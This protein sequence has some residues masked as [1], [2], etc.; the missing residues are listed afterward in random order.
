MYRPYFGLNQLPFKTTPELAMF[1]RDGSREEILQ[2]LEYT[3]V[4]GDGILK[5]VGE[6]GC[7]KTMI[8]RLL[9]NEL[10][11][12]FK[13]IYV[14]SPNLSAK[15]MLLF[16]CSELGV[17]VNASEQKFSLIS[18]LQKRLL[19]LYSQGKKVVML[20]DEAQSMTLDGLEEIRLLSNLETD[21]D[22]LLQVVLF[23]Q[24]ELDRALEHPNIR[25]LKSRIT[26]SIYIPPFSIQDVH[27]YLNFR[28]RKSGY[29][30]VDVF[31][32]SAAKKITKL[33]G[34]YP[35]DINVVADKL[36]MSVFSKQDKFV[37]SKH[38]SAIEPNRQNVQWLRQASVLL[39]ILLFAGSY[40]L[41]ANNTTGVVDV[42]SFKNK[43]TS[44]D[45][46]VTKDDIDKDTDGVKTY[47]NS[48]DAEEVLS[49]DNT[50]FVEEQSS[51]ADVESESLTT[52][53]V[54]QELEY[55]SVQAKLA[56]SIKP[57]LIDSQ[58]IVD[59]LS[60]NSYSIQLATITLDSYPRMQREFKRTGVDTR[61]IF[62]IL[63]LKEVE[64][65]EKSG[66]LRL[67]V[68][69]GKA[70][71]YSLAKQMLQGLPVSLQRSKPF[72]VSSRIIKKEFS[73]AL[74]F[75]TNTN[76]GSYVNES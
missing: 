75:V 4:R 63:D 27:S 8:L 58:G 47:T 61:E 19:Q 71:S 42:V 14:N 1:Y 67:K 7:G 3:V 74:Q 45:S 52:S 30:G 20:I 54:N 44:Y 10:D 64:D 23:G 36:L 28:M 66:F 53:R 57:F 13:L 37:R 9:A 41:Y 48:H 29:S 21:S 39:V 49:N 26:Y 60:P 18:L 15:D 76:G 46:V 40:W 51:N 34:G 73:Q 6:V 55:S 2:A 68:Y 69:L 22:K 38:F 17:E 11:D 70:A 12:S 65:K 59:N 25:Q 50:N 72:I 33:T 16:I 56:S 62:Y 5:V 24:P 31:S 35:R 32:L 43:P